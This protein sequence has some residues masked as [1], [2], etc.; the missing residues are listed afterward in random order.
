MT[1]FTDRRVGIGGFI[2]W[3]EESTFGTA[4]AAANYLQIAPGDETFQLDQEFIEG[5]HTNERG[6]DTADVVK[7]MSAVSGTWAHDLRYGGGWGLLL[8]HLIADEVLTAG[9]SPYTH[10]FDVGVYASGMAGKGISFT[11]AR[12]GLLVGGSDVADRYIGCRPTAVT[13][14]CEDNAIAR[15]EWTIIGA[16][17]G[18][19]A[20][21]TPTFP[22]DNYMK[23]PSDAGSP[24]AGFK[25]GT[26][27]SEDTYP[28]RRWSLTIS[29]PWDPVRAVQA[30]AMSEPTLGGRIEVTGSC[31][32]LFQGTGASGDTFTTNYRAGTAASMILTLE[33]PTAANESLVIDMPTV[34]ITSPPDAHMSETGAVWQTVEFKAYRSGSGHEADITLTNSDA[35]LNS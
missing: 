9:A 29:Q 19:V 28:C 32:V 18:T 14:T 16:S 6:V 2:G 1:D 15:A 22:T 34:R 24:T 3:A 20:I 8:E 7:G 35:A 17:A 21:P 12:D 26:D 30:A 10:D 23:A 13:I 11:V 27:T 25:Y 33:G 4:A 31:E 5:S